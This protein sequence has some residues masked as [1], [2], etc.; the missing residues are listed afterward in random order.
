MPHLA[1]DLEFAFLARHRGKAVQQLVDGDRRKQ[2]VDV[3][4]ADPCQHRL[5]VG[6]FQW[7]IAHQPFSATKAS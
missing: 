1:F 6:G 4:N 2:L 7:Q 5:A 3:G